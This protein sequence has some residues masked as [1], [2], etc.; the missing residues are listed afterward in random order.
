MKGFARIIELPEHDVLLTKSN[1]SHHNDT[2]QLKIT[3]ALENGLHIDIIGG[4]PE[5]KRQY[6]DERFATITAEEVQIMVD[7]QKA[8]FDS[9]KPR[10][11]D[12]FDSADAILLYRSRPSS[13]TVAAAEDVDEDNVDDDDLYVGHDYR[14]QDCPVC[15]YPLSASGW[16]DA[17]GCD[18][19]LGS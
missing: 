6:R 8:T 13:E 7:K 19:D 2:P 9:D 17:N 11:S 4:Y 15:G 5:E 1:D 14:D 3:F 12:L 18:A 10:V 16:C